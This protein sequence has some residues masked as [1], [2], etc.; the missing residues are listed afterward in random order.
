[1]NNTKRSKLTNRFWFQLHGWFSLPLWILFCFIALTGSI[2]SISHELTWLTNPNARATNPDSVSAK[3]PDDIIQIVQQAHPSADISGMSTFEPYLVNAVL[4]SDKDKPFA[5]AYVNQYTGEIQEINTG[6]TFIT[7]MRSLHGWLLFPWHHG[8]S[9][10]YYLVSLFSLLLMGAVVTG[11]I[12]YKKFWRAFFQF[13]LRFHQGGRT[14]LSDLHRLC[15]VWS[16]WFMIIMSLTG[17]WYLIQAVMWHNDVEIDPYPNIIPVEHIPMQKTSVP[18]AAERVKTALAAAKA[19]YP[20]FELSYMML[21]E[22][23]RDTLKLYGSG[24]DIFYDNFSYVVAV[25]PWSGN[26]TH[27]LSPD[28]MNLTQSVMHIADPLH[29]GY[30]GGLWTKFIWFFFGLVLSGMMLSGFL[31]WRKRVITP[32]AKRPATQNKEVIS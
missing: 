29:F 24:N 1:M 30:I 19:T 16:I 5:I 8:Y 31:M 9:V 6:T 22:H 10:G 12:V 32:K 26:V 4:F 23:N 15:G 21:P 14:F 20:D 18:N 3:S 2:A 13:K 7:F 25:D 11:M 27:E 17:L 28:N